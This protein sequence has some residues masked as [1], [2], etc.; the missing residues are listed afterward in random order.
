MERDGEGGCFAV[1]GLLLL[2]G[3][4]ILAV[5]W[6][7]SLVGHA[8]DLTP[9]YP[10]IDRHDGAWIRAHY[11]EVALGYVLTVLTLLVGLPA[12]IALSV[13]LW[14]D[15]PHVRRCAGLTALLVVLVLAIAFAPAGRIR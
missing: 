7:V 10:E 3:G 12:S 13:E 5:V 6:F 14:A 9:T 4:V 11:D 1:F 2:V 8:L 15:R